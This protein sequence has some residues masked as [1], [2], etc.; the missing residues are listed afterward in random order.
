MHR[1]FLGDLNGLCTCNKVIDC[2]D[3]RRQTTV[4]YFLLD[5]IRDTIQESLHDL[6]IIG[7]NDH[8]LG[9]VYQDIIISLDAG[10]GVVRYTKEFLTHVL[11]GRQLYTL[12][13]Q[14]HNNLFKGP[15]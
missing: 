8:I 10:S 3:F 5:I 11:H 13:V 14:S 6:V 7:V 2:V 1:G 9:M 4:K 15:A 12:I